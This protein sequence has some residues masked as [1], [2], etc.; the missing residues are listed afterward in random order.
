[1]EDIS[2]EEND[3]M[4]YFLDQNRNKIYVKK[5]GK[6]KGLA[7][8]IIDDIGLSEIYHYR[9][10]ERIPA[11]VFLTYCGYVYVDEAEEKYYKPWCNSEPIK[12]KVVIYCS[13]V[14]DEDYIEYLKTTYKGEENVIEDGYS[15][16]D[17]HIKNLIDE[18]IERIE[19]I[20]K[21]REKW[22]E[23]QLSGDERE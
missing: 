18:I 1:M 9:Y 21:E 16:E 3:K 8:S 2:D 23:R 22:K 20:I 7:Y 19:P 4:K 10:E 12:Y 5:G 6:H 14:I 11:P 17:I 13:K 15:T